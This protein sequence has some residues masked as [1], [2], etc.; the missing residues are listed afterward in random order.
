MLRGVSYLT[1]ETM[2]ILV[3]KLLMAGLFFLTLSQ[4]QGLSWAKRAWL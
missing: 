1:P 3:C 2:S 4:V